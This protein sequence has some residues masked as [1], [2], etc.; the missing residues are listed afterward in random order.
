M[1]ITFN[2]ICGLN[3]S[4]NGVRKNS[5]W[6]I[7]VLLENYGPLSRY[8]IDPES[9]ALLV[10]ADHSTRVCNP[11]DFITQGAPLHRVPTELLSV[12]SH[13]FSR[14]DHH[15]PNT[16]PEVIMAEYADSREPSFIRAA[17]PM[18]R[19]AIR[20]SMTRNSH[21]S[22]ASVSASTRSWVYSTQQNPP[23]P[24]VEPIPVPSPVR[25]P[26]PLPDPQLQPQAYPQVFHTTNGI[27][28]ADEEEYMSIDPNVPGLDAGYRTEGLGRG[29]S[30]R[31]VATNPTNPRGEGGSRSFVGGFVNGLRRLPKVVMRYGGSGEKRKFTRRGTFGTEGTATSVT[32]M[33]TG[34]TLPMYTSNPTTPVAGPSNVRYVQAMEMPPVPPLP[35]T[36]PQGTIGTGIGSQ[37]RRQPSFRITPPSEVTEPEETHEYPFPEVDPPQFAQAVGSSRTNA[38]T[39]TVL[40][41]SDPPQDLGPPEDGPAPTPNRRSP[42][43]TQPQLQGESHDP[44]PTQSPVLA[45]PPPAEDYRRMALSSS[46]PASPITLTTTIMTSEPSFSS[47]LNPIKRF[48]HTL[49][50]MPWVAH[51]RVTV[52]YRPGGKSGGRRGGGTKKPMASWYRGKPGLVTSTR[53]GSGDVDLLSGGSGSN[54]T[55]A[56]TNL[57]PL[58]SP[59]TDRSRHHSSDH[60]RRRREHR[61]HRDRDR[62]HHSRRRDTTSTAAEAEMMHQ[63][64]TSPILPAVYPY[65]YPYSYGYPTFPSPPSPHHRAPSQST[66]R[67]PRSHRTPPYHH[68]YPQYQPPPPAPPVYVFQQSP[69][70][71]AGS[72]E[73]SQGQGQVMSPVYVPMQFVPGAF[74]P[75]GLGNSPTSSPTVRPAVAQ[76]P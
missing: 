30:P 17:D 67:G 28:P 31:V 3:V 10:H 26:R 14:C 12:R 43:V 42:S 46:S 64:N 7:F 47:E 4:F 60:R 52:D 13:L 22:H 48:F 66:P 29:R 44:T 8:R 65:P 38:D 54:R 50:T 25:T 73:L 21:Y 72:G 6:V 63:R 49:H 74:N 61:H 59:H 37:R 45:H 5:L 19:D 24:P 71:T 11:C 75:E 36:F 20:R 57:T 68:G 18:A 62:D 69:T 70:P 16:T 23:P 76:Q 51:D 2:S 27:D 15:T 41:Y 9:L 53:T 58:A 56:G 55:S 40:V 32:G 35:E 1:R 34:N 33:T 39:T